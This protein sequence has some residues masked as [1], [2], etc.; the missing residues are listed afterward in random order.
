MISYKRQDTGLAA[1]GGGGGGDGTAAALRDG[2]VA[3]GYSVFLDARE[4]EGGDNYD[5]VSGGGHA[6]AAVVHA[7]FISL[8]LARERAMAQQHACC[9]L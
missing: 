8:A 5:A 4:L 9:L 6:T 3:A 7:G 2:L 1:A